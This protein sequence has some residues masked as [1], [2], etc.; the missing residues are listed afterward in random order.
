MWWWKVGRTREREKVLSK[1]ILYVLAGDIAY[2]GSA[3]REMEGLCVFF[4]YVT[5]CSFNIGETVLL[6]FCTPA[7]WYFLV[8]PKFLSKVWDRVLSHCSNL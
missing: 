1:G 6:R 8:N 4:Y 5:E 2:E 3:V 7:P